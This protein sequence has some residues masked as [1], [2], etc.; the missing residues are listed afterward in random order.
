MNKINKFLCL[1]YPEKVLLF[2]AFFLVGIIRLCLLIFPLKIIQQTV[3][4]LSS[5]FQKTRNN[6]M[7]CEQISWAVKASANYLIGPKSCLP[8]ALAAQ[9]LLKQYGYPANLRFG[10]YK[11][12]ELEAHASIESQGKIIVGNEGIEYY[13]PLSA[14]NK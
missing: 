4:F 9:M 3:V 7:P 11:G 10:V 5:L 13:T 8:Q 12:N 2:K 6:L 14:V 1:S